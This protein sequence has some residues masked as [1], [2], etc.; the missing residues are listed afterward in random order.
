V[1]LKLMEMGYPRVS[2]LKGGWIE[3][4]KSGYPIEKK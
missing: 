1:A 4:E 3:W 2:A